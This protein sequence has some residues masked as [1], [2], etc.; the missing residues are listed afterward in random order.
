ML[1]HG[2]F[3]YRNYLVSHYR[4]YLCGD[5]SLEVRAR[6]TRPLRVIYLKHILCID[7]DPFQ[8]IGAVVYQA[9]LKLTRPAKLPAG[10]EW[11]FVY[12]GTLLSNTESI[13]TVFDGTQTI[14]SVF[15]RRELPPPTE[16]EIGIFRGSISGALQKTSSQTVPFFIT[17][18][19]ERVAGKKNT[20]GIYRKSGLQKNMDTIQDFV[21]H[22]FDKA[23]IEAF[24]DKQ[25]VHDLACVLKFYIR[26]L[27]IPV[28]PI[29]LSEEFKN[30]LSMTNI[31]HSLQLLKVLITCLPTS[32]YDFLKAFCAHLAVITT[33]DN[34]MNYGSLALVLGGNFF[35]GSSCGS[36][37]VG[38]MGLFQ[39]IAQ[40]IFQN[41][42]YVFFN[43]PLVIRDEYV[44]TLQEVRTPQSLLSKG[45]RLKMVATRGDTELTADYCGTPVTLQLAN[46]KKV[47][48]DNVP[49]D[50][51]VWVKDPL[52]S[53]IATFL[54]PSDLTADSAQA[55]REKV[56]GDLAELAVI[57]R[58]LETALRKRE[59]DGRMEELNRIARN[60]SKF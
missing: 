33:G 54:E 25:M 32:H 1:P 24:L 8:T 28:I 12:H 2:K 6:I 56:Q 45:Q 19:M 39:N 44:L 20:E 46:V 57:E 15:L 34:H 36:D 47:V 3:L 58:D 9:F 14:P 16:G 52:D 37:M 50:F 26:T 51:W 59:D 42:R 60:L 43:D 40:E 41:W 53:T 30:T 18:I 27:G 21:E 17:A 31:R 5:S 4:S 49:P 13:S 48:A 23:A 38:E 11:T 7:C 22:N 29:D 55:L 10:G 35:R